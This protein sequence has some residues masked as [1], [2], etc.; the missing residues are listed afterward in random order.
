MYTSSSI[1]KWNLFSWLKSV[2]NST[3]KAL[4]I[5][6]DRCMYTNWFILKW[7][8]FSWLK[9]VLSSARKANF[10]VCHYM[11]KEVLMIERQNQC[12]FKLYKLCFDPI[13]PTSLLVWHNQFSHDMTK[14]TKWVC[15]QRRLRSAWASAQTQISLGI[16][17]VSSES[18]LCAQ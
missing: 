5:R 8:L 7:N 16:R 11:V 10:N 2:I 17:S 1:L 3:R 4:Q 9:I 6:H 13:W 15:A 14:P 18:S 12:F